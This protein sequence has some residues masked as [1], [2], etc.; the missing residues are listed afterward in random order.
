MSGWESRLHDELQSVPDTSSWNQPSLAAR[1]VQD[2]M[3]L[4]ADVSEHDPR[5]VWG[6]LYRWMRVSPE[7]LVMVCVALAAMVD[8]DVEPRAALA[9]TDSLAKEAA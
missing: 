2:A 5:V 3:R 8:P 4:I 6:R 1:G 9:W 7:R